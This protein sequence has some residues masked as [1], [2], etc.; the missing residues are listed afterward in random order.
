M[1]TLSPHSGTGH[2]F[3]SLSLLIILLLAT[4]SEFLLND[5][6]PQLG[7]VTREH[8]MRSATR[9][10]WGPH[11]HL[12]FDL[13]IPRNRSSGTYFRLRLR[14]A[15][16]LTMAGIAS[17]P[18]VSGRKSITGARRGGSRGSLADPRAESLSPS[19]SR[20]NIPGESGIQFRR[21]ESQ[22]VLPSEECPLEL[23]AGSG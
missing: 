6:R 5:N 16:G 7:H 10:L 19:R 22:N 14:E 21:S 11:S 20:R 23:D 12:S 9:S 1:R 18:C 8:R 3:L 17:K 15:S 4:G 13:K 2:V